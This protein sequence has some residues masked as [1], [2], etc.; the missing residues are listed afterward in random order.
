LSGR[1]VENSKRPP[2]PETLAFLSVAPCGP[3]KKA[4]S[5]ALTPSGRFTVAVAVRIGKIQ[6]LPVTFH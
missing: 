6:P 3:V 2:L 1:V 5:V 4:V